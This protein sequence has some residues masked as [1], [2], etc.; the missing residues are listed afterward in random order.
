MKPSLMHP[1]LD[2][3]CTNIIS[4]AIPDFPSRLAEERISSLIQSACKNSFFYRH[5]YEHVIKNNAPFIQYPTT[6]KLEMMNNFDEIVSD[7]DIKIG[8]VRD[9]VS[10]PSNIGHRFLDKYY[11]WESSGTNGIQGLYLQDDDSINTYQ[12]LEAFRRPPNSLCSQFLSQSLGIEKIAFIG[13]LNKHY[14]STISIAILKSK[15]PGLKSTIKEFSIFDPIEKIVSELNKY[16]PSVVTTYP[17]M[18]LSLIE[19]ARLKIEPREL[20]LGG[21]SLSHCQREYI[22]S[23]LETKIYNSYGAS[24][25]LPIAWDCGEGHLHVNA[26]WVLLE[27]VDNQYAPVTSGELSTT[28]LLTNLANHI[29]PIIRFDLGDRINYATDPC[30]CGSK[31]PHLEVMGRSN[32]TLIFKNSRGA[33]VK[34]STLTLM[35]LI[36]REGIFN[37]RISQNSESQIQLSLGNPYPIDREKLRTATMS[38]I[39]FLT[40]NHINNIDIKFNRNRY[41]LNSSSGKLAL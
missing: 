26:D 41:K 22:E 27:A 8:N 11:V 15:Y 6:N 24:E 28:T 10:N 3:W 7:K 4:S 16:K 5:K 9:F 21:E 29:Q 37:A 17:S 31:L 39:D 23:K 1:V 34:I 20:W 40:I 18:V 25:F 30:K 33:P 12:A 36:E 35:E 14:A 32:E 19:N 13:A 2:I 38:V